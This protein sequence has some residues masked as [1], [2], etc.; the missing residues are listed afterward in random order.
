[1]SADSADF[2][3]VVELQALSSH[4]DQFA[5][6]RA[7]AEVGTHFIG[8]GAKV[9]WEG[10]CGERDHFVGVGVREW[11][12]VRRGVGDDDICRKRHLKTIQRLLVNKF[13]D[14]WK[15]LGEKPYGL[16]GSEQRVKLL[17]GRDG[18]CIDGDEGNDVGRIAA[19]V[20]A[21]GD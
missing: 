3:E 1:M 20:V 18:G 6:R 11:Q 21:G 16:I 19:C 9:A 8:A 5:G 4:G 12:D 10:E 17:H 2:G 7:N 13:G 15:V 14:E